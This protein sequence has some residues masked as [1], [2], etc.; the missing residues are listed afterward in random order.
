MNC[1]ALTSARIMP[2]WMSAGAFPAVALTPASVTGGRWAER[3]PRCCDLVKIWI[4]ASRAT[5]S[6]APTLARWPHGK[7][8]SAGDRRRHRARLRLHQRVPRHRQRDGDLDRDRGA[9][10]EVAV[11]LSAV[12]NF[13]GAFLSLA[14][15]ATIAKASSTRARSRSTVVFAGLV[16]GIT[17]NLVTW[18]L[19]LPSSSS[20]ALIG[21]VVGATLIAA[22][23][24][25]GRSRRASFRRCSSRRSWHR[26][27]RS[28]RHC[29]HYRLPHHPR[30]RARPGTRA[31]SGS[32][33]SVPPRWSRSR[34]AR[35]TRRRRWASSRSR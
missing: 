35:T 30:E 14:V 29:R 22:G 12:L 18:Y 6:R 5:P 32:G 26:C 31:G 2:L 17:W 21:G 24:A 16:G 25:R 4:P 20:H 11:G 13:V 23:P 8:P 19:G 15:A 27:R 1:A 7:R 28:R 33:R 34:T 9:A 3:S 10:A